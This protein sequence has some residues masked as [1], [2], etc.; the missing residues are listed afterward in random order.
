LAED[1]S[2]AVQILTIHKAKGLE[3]P[4]V[5]L[6][7]LHQGSGREK[8]AAP[9]VYD[10]ST[11]SY[12]LSTG[13]H[14]TLAY[15][16][17]QE[18]QAERERAER[19]RLL[20]VG[21]TRAKDLLVLSG[22]L[23]SRPVGDTVL[24]W[25]QEV[26]EGDIGSA[27]T[28]SLTIGASVLPHRVVHAPTRKWPRRFAA[29]EEDRPQVDH[30]S[31]A[32][33]WQERTARWHHIRVGAWH[34]TPTA[35]QKQASPHELDWAAGGIG[36]DASRL[37]GV[38]AHRLLEEWDF[39]LPISRFL[40]RIG[41]TLDRLVSP[42]TA[43]LKAK[44]VEAL[45]EIFTTFGSSEPYA[46]LRAADILGREIP[47]IM[48]WGDGQ[49]MEGVIDVIYC[50]DGAIRIADYKTDRTTTFDAPAR[51]R[52]YS[53]Q[54]AIYREAAARCLGHNDISFECVF[55]GAGISVAV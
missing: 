54:A 14:E 22:G 1:A 17:V 23:T 31:L 5:V 41:P 7:G 26:G 9:V 30:A 8:T 55:L 37:V 33:L 38:A 27:D 42:E 11:G 40:E 44:A 43:H 47:F 32:R 3:F 20:Y 50:L 24:T 52:L 34:L 49:I 48:P 12:G 25:L 21:M 10:W 29:T 39:R 51:A 36:R 6:P 53:E 13:P 45:T 46:R 35:L 19:R 15:A 18:K 28:K 16:R 2:D 4:I